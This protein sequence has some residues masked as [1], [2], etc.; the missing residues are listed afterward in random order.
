MTAAVIPFPQQPSASNPVPAWQK[1][2]DWTADQCTLR[3]AT[4]ELVRH[5]EPIRRAYLK[6]G[7]RQWGPDMIVSSDWRYGVREVFYVDNKSQ[8]EYRPGPAR[9]GRARLDHQRRRPPGHAWIYEIHR[10]PPGANAV[11][12]RALRRGYAV[13]RRPHRGR[14]PGHSLGRRLPTPR[15]SRRAPHSRHRTRP[16]TTSLGATAGRCRSP[17]ASE[18]CVRIPTGQLALVTAPAGPGSSN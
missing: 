5:P 16:A 15:S 14:N 13:H 4:V 7:N 6:Q 12:I 1:S 3:G 10:R 9:T 17:A 2:E 18:G 11:L 8:L